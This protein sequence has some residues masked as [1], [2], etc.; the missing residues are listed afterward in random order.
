M[1][2]VRKL[3]STDFIRM[4][5]PE[6]FWL[7]TYEAIGNAKVKES[8]HRYLQGVRKKNP[9]GRGL[10]LVGEVGTGKTAIAAV[11]LK[12]ARSIGFPG[13]FVSFWELREYIRAKVSFDSDQT[14]FDRCRNV[15]FLVLDD[16]GV[17]DARDI[18]LGDRFLEGLV[19]YRASRRRVTII[20]TRLK[21]DKLKAELG[22]LYLVI[23]RYFEVIPVVSD[24]R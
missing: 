10:L 12:Y 22:Q 17:G 2:V 7:V 8:V 5:L 24:L 14:V 21:V 23:G 16:F 13:F 19:T 20:T 15:D 1:D 3:D 4:N 6:E 11:V 9:V 18:S